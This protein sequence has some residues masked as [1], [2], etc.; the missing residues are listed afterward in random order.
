MTNHAR[1]NL[2]FESKGKLLKSAM[3]MVLSIFIMS[4]GVAISTR[5]GLGTSPIS[6]LPYVLSLGIPLTYG[7]FTFIMNAFLI[8]FQFLLLKKDLSV[9]LILQIPVLIIFSFFSDWTL[10]MV[11]F[12]VP[13]NYLEQWVFTILSTI[14]LAFGISIEMNA[15]FATMPGEGMVFALSRRF[16][17]E[18]GRMKVVF[19]VTLVLSAVIASVLMFGG[20]VGVREGTIFAALTVGHIVRFLMKLMSNNEKTVKTQVEI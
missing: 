11:Q 7:T 10:S 18:F 20:L 16:K 3:L 19:D 8:L 17:T 1:K 13:S 14:I 4:F 9:M 2:G 12:I 5:A 6:S 15:K